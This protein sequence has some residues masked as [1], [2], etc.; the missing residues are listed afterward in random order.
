M[1]LSIYAFIY[2]E[3][4]DSGVEYRLKMRI[5]AFRMM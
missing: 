2:Y 5:T 4:Q 3:M 1:L